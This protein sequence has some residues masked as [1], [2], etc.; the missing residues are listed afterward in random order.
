MALHQNRWV[1]VLAGLALGLQLLIASGLAMS[2][3]SAHCG[4]AHTQ[5]MN[6]DD[7]QAC[8]TR[9]DGTGTQSNGT[10]QVACAIASGAA[11]LPLRVLTIQ[12]P[13]DAAPTSVASLQDQSSP[14]D[15]LRPPAAA[16]VH[17]A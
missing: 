14:D 4:S 11:P 12:A 2:A 15:L 5:M 10:C 7:C 9:P 16:A 17:A 8:G 3:P 6:S 13:R 1:H